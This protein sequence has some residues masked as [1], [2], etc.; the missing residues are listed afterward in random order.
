LNKYLSRIIDTYALMDLHKNKSK[1]FHFYKG[2]DTPP[3]LDEINTFYP[4]PN[5]PEITFEQQD[6]CENYRIGKY[7]YKSEIIDNGTSNDYSMGSY[8]KSNTCKQHVSVI[9]VHGWRMNSFSRIFNIYLKQ[10]M[11][12]E[13]NIYAFT[14]PYHFERT[15]ETSLYSGEYMVSAN[16]DRTL[17]SIKQAVTDLRALIRYLK[18]KNEKVI[19]IGTSLGGFLTNLA[20]VIEEGIDILVSVL[21]A[22]S[23]SFSVWKSIPGKYMKK[24][25]E[26]HGFTYEELKRYWAILEPSNYKPVV[27]KEN[28]LLISGIYDRYVL[29]ED[30][31]FLWEAWDK[32]QRI[33]YPCGHSGIAFC[34]D[35]I[36]MD[37][38]E[39]LRGRI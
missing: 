16:V 21:Y 23:L 9:L 19:L 24:D 6:F 14:L 3:S 12:M 22:N 13:Y 5:I 26:A 37:T 38:V 10:F 7:K 35:K 32:P 17:I 39:F 29:R 33:L 8:Y 25:F 20:G 18:G 4:V 34:K 36:R 1:T 30:T 2:I 15:P 11:E 28:I 31:D 27:P